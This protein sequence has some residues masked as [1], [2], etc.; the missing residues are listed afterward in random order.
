MHGLNTWKIEGSC[1]PSPPAK[2]RAFSG[3]QAWSYAVRNLM[4]SKFMI[5]C[6]QLGTHGTLIIFFAE[7]VKVGCVEV[8]FLYLFCTHVKGKVSTECQIPIACS[9]RGWS[10]QFWM[11]SSNSTYLFPTPVPNLSGVHEMMLLQ[12]KFLS[13]LPTSLL[14]A[15]CGTLAN[16]MG[17]IPQSGTVP[18]NS[19]LVLRDCISLWESFS[20][21]PPKSPASLRNKF[22]GVQKGSRKDGSWECQWLCTMVTFTMLHIP[23]A[24]CGRWSTPT[25]LQISKHIFHSCTWLQ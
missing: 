14:P 20:R 19:V 22:C 3:M 9:H 23:L 8:I 13:P 5:A 25:S 1:R 6:V 10:S 17:K 15:C 7:Y 24:F 4:Q 21:D 12:I 2:L 11:C 18:W 16:S